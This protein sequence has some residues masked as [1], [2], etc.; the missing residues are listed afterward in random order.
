MRTLCSEA[1]YAYRM[2]KHVI[3]VSVDEDHEPDGWIGA[4]CRNSMYYNLSDPDKFDDEMEKLLGR[5]QK[6]CH[7]AGRHCEITQIFTLVSYSI[8]KS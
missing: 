1:E 7:K 4:L 2:C 8:G 3:P 6:L 5:L